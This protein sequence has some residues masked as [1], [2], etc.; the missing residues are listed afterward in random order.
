VQVRDVHSISLREATEITRWFLPNLI[1][2]LAVIRILNAVKV[3][4]MLVGA[5]A[6]GGWTRESRGTT[7]V[8][9][10]VATRGHRK[11]VRA[12]QD[13]FPTLQAEDHGVATRLRDPDSGNVVIDVMRPNQ[14]MY[15]EALQHRRMVESEGQT[16]AIPTLELALAMKFSA[17][18]SLNRADEKKHSDAA[19]FI[20]M[21]KANANIDLK[22][23]AAFGELV[24][25]GGGAEIVGKVEE[26]RAGRRLRL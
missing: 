24:Y 10:L 15:Q 19:D 5:Y 11:A 22:S 16:Y 25:N 26:V 13:E 2:P 14:S 23:L 8:D 1:T 18:F 3:R 9:V 7:N 21:V 17:M 4:F 20:R 12:L 6:I